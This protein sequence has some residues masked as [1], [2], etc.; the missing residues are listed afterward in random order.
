M[1]TIADSIFHSRAIRTSGLRIEDDPEPM[2]QQQLARLKFMAKAL[3]LR[4]KRVLEFGCGTGFNV[5]FI[6]AEL[7][8][9]DVAGFDNS[10]GSIALAKRQF[11]CADL[12]VGDACDPSLHIH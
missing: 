2:V 7:G 4:G 3:D 9:S 11:P 8:A 10:A 6:K 12:L 5:A 1:A